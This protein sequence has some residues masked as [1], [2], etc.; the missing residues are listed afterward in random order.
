[1]LRCLQSGW[2]AMASGRGNRVC[3]DPVSL[4]LLLMALPLDQ[5]LLL[6]L[7]LLPP[8]LSYR[9]VVEHFL[10]CFSAIRSS[11]GENSQHHQKL[12]RE[13]IL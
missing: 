2:P 7:L 5:P 3:L 4:V 11:S 1:M 6:L 8:P 13:F 10:R 9:S 12:N